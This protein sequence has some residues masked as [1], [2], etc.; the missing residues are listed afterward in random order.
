MNNTQVEKSTKWRC[1]ACGANFSEP[2]I[3]E[4]CGTSYCPECKATNSLM[5]MEHWGRFVSNSVPLP[6]SAIR[7]RQDSERKKSTQQKRKPRMGKT[8]KIKKLREE[9]GM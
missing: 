2:G 6:Y 8:E 4:C 9:L 3:C 5:N 7:K 1:T